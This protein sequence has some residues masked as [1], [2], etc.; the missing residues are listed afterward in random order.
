MFILT[1]AKNKLTLQ[2][3]TREPLTSGS[4]NVNTVRF[5]F[6]EEWS[7]LI[8]TAVFKAGAE[9]RSVLLDETGECVIPW[10][11][12][13]EPGV[14]LYAGLYGKQGSEIVLPTVWASLG[15]ILE[16]VSATGGA[17]RPPTPTPGNGVDDHRLLTHR[18]A[19]NQ[20]P[21]KAIGGLSEK[22]NAIP[23]P[24]EALTNSELEEL[25]K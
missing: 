25:L 3:Q 6:S 23:Q 17:A 14:T 15:T 16:G 2:P 12:L 20:H 7:G 19:E 13:T 1:A 4:V 5:E 11:V 9:S 24:V 21:I 10:E 22:L 8:R 18:D